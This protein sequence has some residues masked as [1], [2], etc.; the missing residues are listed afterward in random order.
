MICLNNTQKQV[1]VFYF[2]NRSI[3][4]ETKNI[5][6]IWKYHS[7]ITHYAMSPINLNTSHISLKSQLTIKSFGKYEKEI[8]FSK[9][10]KNLQLFM[11]VPSQFGTFRQ[12]NALKLNYSI[13][14][15]LTLI[16][17]RTISIKEIE[18][19]KVTKNQHQN[20]ILRF[21]QV[22][23]SFRLLHQ[24]SISLI[25]YQIDNIYFTFC[26]Y[27]EYINSFSNQMETH[28][29]GLQIM[30]IFLNQ[31]KCLNV[32]MF[33]NIHFLTRTTLQ[34]WNSQFGYRPQ[35]PQCPDKV[36][37]LWQ[38]GQMSQ[39]PEIIPIIYPPRIN[40]QNQSNFLYE[41]NSVSGLAFYRKLDY[42]VIYYNMIRDSNQGSRQIFLT[43][44]LIQKKI[45][46]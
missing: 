17:L 16:G 43:T 26:G 44:S 35:T 2:A 46:C 13:K 31:S 37:I 45:L 18:P 5:E 12:I 24:L 27:Y 19:I 15:K 1:H 11:K 4:R 6:I 21:V 23:L 22:Q 30:K 32:E 20:V 29:Q 25:E 36:S 3:F 41:F 38:S 10:G 8:V 9:D 28:L 14:S 7:Y 33:N 34:E 42:I 39:F 40:P